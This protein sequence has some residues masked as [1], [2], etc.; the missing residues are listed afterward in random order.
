MSGGRIDKPDTVADKRLKACLTDKEKRSFV[1]VAGAGSGK[2]TSLVKAL[3]TAIQNRGQELQRS[4]RRIA[5][6]TYTELAA[7]EI[8]ADVANNPLLHVST[9]HSFLWSITRSFQTDIK[10]WVIHRINERIAELAATAANFGPRVKERTRVKNRSDIDRYSAS[11]PL[12]EKVV[13]FNYGTGSDYPRGVLGHDDIIR[14]ATYFMLD[15]PLFRTLV[16]QQ[17]P[18][19]FVDESQD[20]Q[21]IVVE[22]LKAVA[23]QAGTD[24]CLGFFGD[25][26]QRIYATGIGDIPPEE[27]WEEITKE[28]NF[29]CPTRVLFVANAIRRDGDHL[30]QTGGRVA[31]DPAGGTP[32]P[33]EGS[34]RIFVLP[35]DG[36][37]DDRLA[38]VR[39]RVSEEVADP[40][41]TDGP[42]ADFK[43]LVIVHR[44]AANRLGFGELYAAMNDKA[45]NAFSEGFLEASS[46]PLKPFVNFVLPVVEA[47]ENGNEF[48][49]MSL[50]RRSCP[51]LQRESLAK[52]K[53]VDLLASLRNAVADLVAMMSD[54]EATVRDVLVHLAQNDLM[55][56]DPRISAFIGKAPP[57]AE[58]LAESAEQDE[59][60]EDEEVASLEIAA[61]DRYL[62]CPARQFRGY[63]TYI[64][65]SSPFS[66]QQGIKGAEFERVLVVLDDDEGTHAQFSYDRY[67]GV[68]P[69]SKRDLENIAEGRQ[70]VIDRTRRLFYVC[71]TRALKDLIVVYFTSDPA[72]AEER[73]RAAN[74][75]PDEDILSETALG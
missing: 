18:I 27:G 63:R 21:P 67:F 58:E 75:F 41:W 12:V 71:C 1:M 36:R 7:T 3:A 14:M 74:I 6:I 8:L 25:P 65:Q 62:A 23:E 5:C 10:A 61:M 33:V 43:L 15:R 53:V 70:T 40:R 39:R 54:D 28:E 56:L 50:L 60:S 9:I 30:V 16:A 55:S 49:A 24:F 32:L 31:V 19:V 44:M 68:K 64:R 22:A 34:A 69:L 20:T 13:A 45:P 73:V 66:T 26:M 29:R 4:R 38:S 2:T 17:F 52:S 72:K 47:M 51:R 48:E 35:A 57:K 46:W 59:E 42:D 37:R 11:I